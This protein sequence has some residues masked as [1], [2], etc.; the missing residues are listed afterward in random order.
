MNTQQSNDSYS[1]ETPVG[2]VTT[3]PF[4][5]SSDDDDTYY[6][7]ECNEDHEEQESSLFSEIIAP[8]II[9]G[10]DVESISLGTSASE[11]TGS[12]R[13]APLSFDVKVVEAKPALNFKT[14]QRFSQ[15]DDFLSPLET[16]LINRVDHLKSSSNAQDSEDESDAEADDMND[17][18]V[19]KDESYFSRL[20]GLST[21][22]V[23]TPAV[24]QDSTDNP[25]SGESKPLI[26]KVKLRM[27]EKSFSPTISTK[28]END[29]NRENVLTPLAQADDVL[30]RMDAVKSTLK[31]GT[32]KRKRKVLSKK[33]QEEEDQKVLK[34]IESHPKD[35]DLT[36]DRRHAASPW[37]RLIILEELGTASSWLILLLPYFSF[38]LAIML[39][40]HE[41]F[42]ESSSGTISA[43]PL[44]NG[45][46]SDNLEANWTAF[47]MQ[48]LPDEA[49]SYRYK[50]EEGKGIL[51]RHSQNFKTVDRDYEIILKYGVAFTSGPIEVPV[52]SSFLYGDIYY[53]SL[54]S[55]SVSLITDGF[56]QYSSVVFQQR[57]E[58]VS[59]GGEWL[60]VS[61]S[62]PRLLSILCEKMKNQTLESDTHWS[63]QSPK[64]VDVLFAS[65]DTSVLTGGKTRVDTIISYAPRYLLHN[66]IDEFRSER[67][68]KGIYEDFESEQR[69]GSDPDDLLLE[70]ARSV[71]Y[72]FTSSSKVKTNVSISV[73]I[74]CLLLSIIFTGF[75]FWSMGITGFFVLDDWLP[76]V[77]RPLYGS[78]EETLL[79]RKKKGE[80]LIE[81]YLN[82]AC[83][84]SASY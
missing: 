84:I 21:Y 6:Y 8:S 16:A 52:L 74:V 28:F 7:R 5:D 22:F 82:N 38:M 23:S 32:S 42:W 27:P 64:N 15:K 76:C 68:D 4:D 14:M 49:C 50:L 73:R 44:C 63:C 51:S 61:I 56:V 55:S 67:N 77:Y 19:S 2:G 80:Q 83:H 79:S 58:D 9:G 48:S 1:R 45:I 36:I 33:K 75:W 30:Q 78:E 41:T 25:S 53:S 40:S 57:S 31:K 20:K 26:E 37:N 13:V 65:P 29:T 72:Q 12:K 60:P 81:S 69:T 71:S 59:T 54:S 11:A 34:T 62:K 39:D 46:D 24:L 18:D 70:I 47:P 35:S 10:G 3:N 43:A 66:K 17:P